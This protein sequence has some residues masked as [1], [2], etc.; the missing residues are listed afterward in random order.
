MSQQV[1]LSEILRKLGVSTEF[2]TKLNNVPTPEDREST[3]TELFDAV[4]RQQRELILND[5]DFVNTQSVQRDEMHKRIT[6]EI[7]GTV[8]SYLRDSLGIDTEFI[9][10][11]GGWKGALKA[12]SEQKVK[13]ASKQA[14]EYE[15]MITQLRDE[16]RKY[17]E[18]ILPKV[19]SEA[20]HQVMAFKTRTL[21]GGELNRYKLNVPTTL[22]DETVGFIER[23]LQEM[24]LRTQVNANGRLD[25]VTAS[26]TK[27]T[28]K[29]GSAFLTTEGILENVLKEAQLLATSNAAGDGSVPNAMV[30][31]KKVE[32]KE[33]PYQGL[34]G[35]RKA[36]ANAA[37][38]SE[39][40]Q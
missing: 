12:Y 33:L 21:L 31:E 28:N 22:H 5:P 16:V 1:T 14:E 29:D 13:P 40:S 38:L 23:K 30:T 9:R 7:A 8:E 18:E 19:Q 26:G 15:R 2:E 6:G 35:L 34:P 10:T 11:N 39:N 3:L 17:N 4:K 27:P 36:E 20:Q 37:R 25:I 24:N 32:R